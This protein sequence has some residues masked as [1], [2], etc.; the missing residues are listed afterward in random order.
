MVTYEILGTSYNS[1]Y[2]TEIHSG[3]V[4]YSPNKKNILKFYSH[5]EK[6]VE[7]I[8]V[9]FGYKF[10]KIGKSEDKP[11]SVKRKKGD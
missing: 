6:N 11:K 7:S 4:G 3:C 1:A 8:I 5:E 2:L 9:K 10:K